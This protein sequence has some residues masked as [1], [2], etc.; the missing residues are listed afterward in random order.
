[1]SDLEQIVRPSETGNVR[2]GP[3]AYLRKTPAA[4]GST[5]VV[6]GSS[7]NSVFQLQASSKAEVNNQTSQETSRTFDTVRIKSK[8][9][10]DTY[11]DVE[12]LTAYQAKNVIDKS[13]T[14]LRFTPPTSSSD[15]EVIARNQTR[16][17]AE[18]E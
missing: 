6:W 18:T 10:P 13:R 12:V 16:K 17:T 3:V 2:P 15:A 9:D 5:E 11:I 4:P 14:Q 7:G 1:M 8:T